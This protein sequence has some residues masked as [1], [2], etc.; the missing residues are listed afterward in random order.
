MSNNKIILFLILTVFEIT[1]CFSNDSTIVQ[2]NGFLKVDNASLCNEIGEKT[3]LRGVSLG[4]H[5]WWSHYYEEETIDWLCRDWNCDVIRA[6]SGVE[7]EGGFVD[8]PAFA[9]RCIEEVVDAS[10]KNGVYVIVDWHTHSIDLEN[11]ICF[12]TRIAKR[13]KD[14]PNIIYEIFNEPEDQDWSEV[15]KYSIEVID[16]IRAIDKRNIILVGSPHWS[17]DVDAVADDPIV[18]YNNLMYSL[19]YYAGTHREDLRKKANYALDKN[20]PLFISEC[21]AMEASGD[22]ELDYKE[23]NKWIMWATNNN[24][25]WIAWSIS[26][27]K[28]SCSMV[29]DR[30]DKV[31]N[32]EERDLTEWGVYCRNVLRN[33]YKD[34]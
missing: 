8:N 24:L 1:F 13:Y 18:G 25:S 33:K 34:E 22:G 2:R 10:I 3:V 12:F 21:A 29:N 4:W 30:V 20:I 11:A 15:K 9:F 17:Q 26:N 27:K 5:N 16:A 32:W 19:H 14:Y 6:A 7:P 28:E 31:S 23:W